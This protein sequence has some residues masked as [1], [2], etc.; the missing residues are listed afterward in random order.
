M[1]R[2]SSSRTCRPITQSHIVT[3]ILTDRSEEGGMGE[4]TI[5]L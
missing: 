5:K 2:R 3:L 1:N 4:I